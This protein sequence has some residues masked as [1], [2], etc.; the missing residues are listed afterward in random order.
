[1]ETCLP[2]LAP[3][4]LPAPGPQEMGGRRRSTGPESG[5]GLQG[6]RS[7]C[8]HPSS[9][10]SLRANLSPPPLA[11]SPAPCP[12][13]AC[14]LGQGPLLSAHTPPF[15]S[16]SPPAAAGEPQNPSLI[17][18]AAS[19]GPCHPRGEAQTL[20]TVPELHHSHTLQAFSHLPSPSRVISKGCAAPI[21]LPLPCLRRPDTLLIWQTPTDSSRINPG[22]T[23]P[24]KPSLTTPS[25]R[26]Y[27]LFPLLLL[28]MHPQG[29][30]GGPVR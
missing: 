11:L 7:P 5:P 25:L 14:V 19:T 15:S 3:H 26:L 2:C 28:K 4:S 8:P 24:R 20:R 12:I 21:A 23:S 6:L 16:P 10:T 30:L 22:V 18:S 27:H 9:P 13:Q 1:M 29:S 17:T